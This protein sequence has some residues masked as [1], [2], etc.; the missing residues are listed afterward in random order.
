MIGLFSHTG[1][2]RVL[3]LPRG[4]CLVEMYS[5]EVCRV[6][7]GAAETVF[8]PDEMKTFFIE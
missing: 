2:R 3:H 6:T 8:E 5:G 7:D 4:N 1:G